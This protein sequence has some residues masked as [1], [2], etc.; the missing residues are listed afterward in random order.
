MS[1]ATLRSSDRRIVATTWQMSS[2][3]FLKRDVLL[4]PVENIRTIKFIKF[5]LIHVGKVMIEP[6]TML[7]CFT[8]ILSMEVSATVPSRID[9]MKQTGQVEI[10]SPASSSWSRSR[11]WDFLR[12]NFE[13][14]LIASFPGSPTSLLF[15]SQAGSLSTQGGQL[16]SFNK[17]EK[18]PTGHHRTKN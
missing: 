16:Y 18:D 15:S 11:L 1:A 3:I 6:N 13:K 17:S 10:A 9:I 5:T 4:V 2:S 12:N 8:Q 14:G 7:K